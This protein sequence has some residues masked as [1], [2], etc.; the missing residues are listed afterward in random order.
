MSGKDQ[1]GNSRT[2]KPQG[3]ERHQSG[4]TSAKAMEEIQ[5]DSLLRPS[6][7]YEPAEA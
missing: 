1:L 7:C 4:T 3:S 5:K 6:F 2:K